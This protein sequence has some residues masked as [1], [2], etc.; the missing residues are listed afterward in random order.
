MIDQKGELWEILVPCN[1]NDGRPVH[2]RHHR[3]WDGMV[4]G[5]TRG[6]TVLRPGVGQWLEG[7]TQTLFRDRIIPVRIMATA[8]QMQEIANITITHYQQRAVMYYRVA[9]HAIIHHASDEQLN[10]FN[11]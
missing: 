1:W 3:V 2:T 8:E 10:K 11:R 6:L 5:I 4:M 9:E 7:Q